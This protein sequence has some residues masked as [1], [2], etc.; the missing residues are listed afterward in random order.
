MAC[1]IG[2]LLT[3][4][5]FLYIPFC[6]LI[7]VSLSEAGQYYTK[8]QANLN[9]DQFITDWVR[10]NVFDRQQGLL[11]GIPTVDAVSEDGR[12]G[13][14]NGDSST[15]TGDLASFSMTASSHDTKAN[16]KIWSRCMAGD[17]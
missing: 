12:Y 8:N 2:P 11:L 16:P 3:S 13:P 6:I 5:Q 4:P 10:R 7:R 15:V 9:A 14:H 1:G 17:G